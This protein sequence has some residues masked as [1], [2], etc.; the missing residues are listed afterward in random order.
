MELWIKAQNERALIKVTNIA[1]ISGGRIVTFGNEY[2][3]NGYFTLGYYNE[4]RALEVLQ[5]IQDIL[6]D[7]KQLSRVIYCMPKK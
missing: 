7:Y 4:E 2:I 5:E 1:L 6:A 3:S